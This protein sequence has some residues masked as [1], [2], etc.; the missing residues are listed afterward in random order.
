M[1]SSW[2]QEVA[3]VH[4]STLRFWSMR[5]GFLSFVSDER[6]RFHFPLNC[7]CGPYQGSAAH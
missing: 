6:F 2:V 7:R 3:S 4:Q 1:V 5:G